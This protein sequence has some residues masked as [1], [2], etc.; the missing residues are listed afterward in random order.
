VWVS[1][2]RHQ[3]FYTCSGFVLAVTQEEGG[4]EGREGDSHGPAD[5]DGLRPGTR[6][7]DRPG[8]RCHSGE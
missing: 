7:T 5:E 8:V 4:E 3:W 2:Y 6:P 1:V